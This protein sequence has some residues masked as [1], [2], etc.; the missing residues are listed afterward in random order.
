MMAKP[1]RVKA[2]PAI[3]DP[4]VARAKRREER[5]RERRGNRLQRALNG[6][7]TRSRHAA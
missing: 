1:S 6:E 7:F 5:K 4:A 3:E 2:K